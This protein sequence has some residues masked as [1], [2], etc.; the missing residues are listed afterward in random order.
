MEPF[1]GLIET[2]TM[3]RLAQAGLT[4]TNWHTTAL[5]SPTRS[6]LMTG[7]NHTTNGMACISECATGFPNANGH[8]PF[9]CAT[10]AEVLSELGFNTYFLANWYLCGEDG[11]RMASSRRIWPIV[12]GFALFY[13]FLG[14]GT[15]EWFTAF[16][17]AS[18]L[19][20][21]HR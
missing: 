5:C 9:E 4:Y 18:H 13:G 7:R 6:C 14:A 16:A 21:Q 20:S 3:N 17:H 8:I 15:T 1:G 19:V 12:C 10:I 11:M 2:P